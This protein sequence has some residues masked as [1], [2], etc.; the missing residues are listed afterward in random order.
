MGWGKKGA[1]LPG[2][3]K[4]VLGGTIRTLTGVQVQISLRTLLTQKS[5]NHIYYLT[6]DNSPSG[7]SDLC[8]FGSS[9]L[10]L[11][12]VFCLLDET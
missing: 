3:E 8:H 1:L 4:G 5:E 2:Q 6:L 10:Q 11:L 7:V 9:L 12:K